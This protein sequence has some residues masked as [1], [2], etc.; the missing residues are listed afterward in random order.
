LLSQ[1]RFQDAVDLYDRQHGRL[2]ETAQARHREVIL[3]YADSA[4]R[5]GE[6][7]RASDLLE[8]YTGLFFK[9]VEALSLLAE[10]LRR[11]G[12]HGAE[13][14][15]L[16]AA[17]NEAHLE[18][19]RRRLRRRLDH[20]VALEAGRIEQQQGP[21]AVIRFYR[22]LLRGEP[23]H[24]PYQIALARAYMEIG[25][26][27]GARDILDQIGD[28]TLLDQAADLRRRLEARSA[29][30]DGIAT[31][32]PLQQIAGGYAVPVILNGRTRATLLID[33][34]ASLTIISPAVLRRAGIAPERSDRQ[35]RFNT[36]NGVVTAPVTRLRTLALSG[37]VVEGLDVGAIALSGVP[38]IDGLLG[39]NFLRRFEFSLS[40]SEQLLS[41]TPLL[42]QQPR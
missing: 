30:A 17:F 2:D 11:D 26:A 9:D 5:N 15:A 42:P 12:R 23:L 6:L 20:A 27:P 8:I 33:T 31:R 29:A 28:P 35:G 22:S 4:A 25:D 13:I 10:V 32:V 14:E 1:D 18:A 19:D 3:R 24:G 16:Y 36:V 39:M 7:E 37:E 38:G 21:Q 40:E 41:L 34:G